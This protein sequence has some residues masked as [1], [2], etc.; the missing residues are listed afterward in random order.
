[1]FEYIFVILITVQFRCLCYLYVRNM[2]STKS[3]HAGN[4]S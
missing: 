4:M 3:G 1:M 2:L